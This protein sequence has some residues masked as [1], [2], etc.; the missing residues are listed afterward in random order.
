ML[1]EIKNKDMSESSL[2]GTEQFLLIGGGI[3]VLGAYFSMILQF[4]LKS[5]CKTIKCCGVEC[6]RDVIEINAEEAQLG[7][8]PAFPT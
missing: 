6:D 4:V 8:P 2:T 5:R 3:T 1:V 7:S